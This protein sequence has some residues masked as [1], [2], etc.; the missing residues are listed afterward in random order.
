MNPTVDLDQLGMSVASGN[1]EL[2]NIY[3]VNND[4][5]ITVTKTAAT[6]DNYQWNSVNIDGNNQF[7]A[8]NPTIQDEKTGKYYTTLRTSF[9][10]K[11]KNPDK[12]KAYEIN[13][14]NGTAIMTPFGADEV[15]PGDLA[16]VLESTSQEPTDNILL[17]YN[18]EYTKT[19]TVLYNKYGHRLHCYTG[20]A[21]N[22][23]QY[24]ECTEGGIGY[25]KVSYNSSKMGTMY[26]LSTKNGVVG[27]WDQV[28][29]GEIVSGNEAYSTVPCQLFPQEIELV[30]Y[31]SAQ[32][33]ITYKLVDSLTVAY[34]D[35]NGV[36]YAK[37]DNG[38]T[39]QAPTPQV[40]EDFMTLHYSQDTYR[41]HSNWVAI[42]ATSAPALKTRIKPTGKV[43]AS[44]PNRRFQATRIEV[45]DNNGN[46]VPNTYCVMNFMPKTSH[47]TPH[48]NFF[49]AAPQANEVAQIIWAQWDGNNTFIVPGS[50]FT[51][52][53]TADFSLY[54]GSYTLTEGNQYKF[55][56]LIEKLPNTKDASNLYKVYP[57]EGIAD[58]TPTGV[59]N[60]TTQGEV[61]N[62][63]Y[64][65][66]AGMAGDQPFD[67]INIVVTTYSDGTRQASKIRF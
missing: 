30:N 20:S 33:E 10:Y 32:D 19:N 23:D 16:V 62:V 60:V 48:H 45:V 31:P 17:P 59:Q 25:F 5:T 66:L 42:E 35:K 22:Y 49:F 4:G 6:N 2:G 24:D 9:S 18:L 53:I 26:K 34:V 11:V 46:F 65:N 21:N 47:S 54:N 44:S 7:F 15:I 39:A 13:E 67:G 40:E 43:I 12:V 61:I 27:F 51:G 57:L 36:I 8:F 37:D 38:A 52:S 58:M 63:R 29:N 1:Q 14:I 55:L 64:Y 41:D 56:A 28:A 50:D 3:I